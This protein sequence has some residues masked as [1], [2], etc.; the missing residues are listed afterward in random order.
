MSLAMKYASVRGF[1]TMTPRAGASFR[2]DD[3]PRVS[4]VTSNRRNVDSKGFSRSE[5]ETGSLYPAGA[6]G[7]VIARSALLI[8]EWKNAGHESGGHLKH[9]KDEGEIQGTGPPRSPRKRERERY[10]WSTREIVVFK[11]IRHCNVH[12]N[13]A[14]SSE[15]T[16]T[17]LCRW[18]LEITLVRLCSGIFPAHPCRAEPRGSTRPS[19]SPLP[20][21]GRS[22]S[23][24]TVIRQKEWRM[25]KH[26][27]WEG[28][29]CQ[30]HTTAER[31]R[32]LMR[33]LLPLPWAC[34]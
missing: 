4:A 33:L 17:S 31:S 20:G 26:G 27:D 25:R 13:A 5:T 32:F 21:L 23:R 7:S 8:P 3:P 19:N 12:Q 2:P 11:R 24:R 29:G 18:L 22:P 16:T 9:T 1:I 10:R 34:T 30:S 6:C 28:G 15:R 14:A